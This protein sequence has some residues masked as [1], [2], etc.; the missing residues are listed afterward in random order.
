MVTITML[1]IP[2]DSNVIKN[3]DKKRIRLSFDFNQFYRFVYACRPTFCLYN[4]NNEFQLSAI[5][6]INRLFL[7]G[8]LGPR[9]NY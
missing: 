1:Y 8:Q 6:T 5:L 9:K 4:N 7:Q 2:P 3:I